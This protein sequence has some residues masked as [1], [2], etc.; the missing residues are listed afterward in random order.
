MGCMRSSVQ[1]VT[2]PVVCAEASTRRSA[3]GLHKDVVVAS[4][5]PHLAGPHLPARGHPPAYLPALPDHHSPDGHPPVPR[6][7]SPRRVKRGQPGGRYPGEHRALPNLMR[8]V[9]EREGR[10]RAL[11]MKLLRRVK[12]G[13]LV[14]K[15]VDT[16]DLKDLRT[17]SWSV[18]KPA[19]PMSGQ[20]RVRGRGHGGRDPERKRFWRKRERKRAENRKPWREKQQKG[21]R[22]AGRARKEDGKSKEQRHQDYKK[23]VNEEREKGKKDEETKQKDFNK[24]GESRNHLEAKKGREGGRK[25]KDR[26]IWDHKKDVKEE[27]EED[28][29]GEEREE[30]RRDEGREE[31][32]RDEERED[33]RDEERE[34]DRRDEEREKAKRDEEREKA[35]RDEERT[36]QELK[37]DGERKDQHEAKEGQGHKDQTK[38][39][40]E[41]KDRTGQREQ[42]KEQIREIPRGKEDGD[43]AA[44]KEDGTVAQ[45][46][47]I[48]SEPDQGNHHNNNSNTNITVVIST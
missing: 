23:G 42:Y 4:L 36:R 27:R 46:W 34:E 29:R 41:D 17:T 39:V 2:C 3:G 43:K 48:H 25:G 16:K 33:R 45:S 47:G 8:R 18:S 26:E 32:R 20:R 5:V 28:R 11:W 19:V 14:G 1:W 15:A 12:T 30:D 10:R 7:L 24:D 35:R 38:T 40:Q 22:R 6:D 21:Q 44:V 37:K 31:D 13:A 9:L